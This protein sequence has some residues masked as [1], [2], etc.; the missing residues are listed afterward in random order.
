MAAGFGQYGTKED[1]INRVNPLSQL[2][3]GIW[4]QLV[5]KSGKK[6]EVKY[7]HCN[8][9]VES[10]TFNVTSNADYYVRFNFDTGYYH[11]GAFSVY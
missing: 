10:V 3:A 9:P 4:V 6:S 2:H 1:A 5:D 7:L 11:S 8:G